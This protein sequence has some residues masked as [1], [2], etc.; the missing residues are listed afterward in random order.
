M[1]KLSEL[2]RRLDVAVNELNSDAIIADTEL[3]AEKEQEIAGIE[4]MIERAVKANE[5]AALLSKPVEAKIEA[6]DDE[7]PSD[8]APSAKNFNLRGAESLSP[9]HFSTGIQRQFDHYLRQARA[10]I[11]YKPTERSFQT[12]GEQL[13]AVFS[14]AM[15]TRAGNPIDNR[16]VRAPTGSSEVDPTGGGFLVQ[17]DFMEA[18]F[19]LAHDMGE[20]LGRVNKIPIS[21]KANGIKINAVD[22]SSRST[23]SRWGGVQ[24]YWVGEGTTVAPS[25]PKFRRVEF[26]LKK[27]FSLAYMT[28]ELLQDSTAMTAI[29]GQ[30]F[31]EEIMFMTEDAIFEGS[32][33]GQ[34]LGVLNSSSLVTVAK[35]SGQANGTILKENID[36]MWSRLWSRSRS[37]A[38]WFVNQDI[39]PSLYSLVQVVG[40]AGAPVYLPPGGYSTSPYAT[41]LGRP[42]I[43]TEYNSA[44][45]TPGDILLADM[46][47]YTLIDKGGVNAATSM[48][49]AFLTDEMVFRVTYRV[50]GKPMW[51]DPITPFKGSN[52]RSPF[53]AIAQR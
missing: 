21:D 28:D 48:H 26:D 44:L 10:H 13:Q 40:T 25:K 31:A 41:L 9:G 34:P 18:I 2:R 53:V 43:E 27:L 30:A 33:A 8:W 38:V 35:Q 49:V 16:L 50:D 52:T 22:E 37:N 23:G 42:V 11:G 45:G 14:A 24:S 29:L 17:T 5:R 15:A 36:A 6:R 19:M 4:L 7:K 12:F 46:S 51:K 1:E 39:L 32:G 20:I 47:Q 3:Y